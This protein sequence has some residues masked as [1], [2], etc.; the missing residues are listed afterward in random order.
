MVCAQLLSMK[1]RN[2]TSSRLIIKSARRVPTFWIEPDAFLR[3]LP[4]I[5]WILNRNS[6]QKILEIGS[7]DFGLSTY[8]K[9]PLIKVDISFQR[10]QQPFSWK[11]KADALKLPFP[12]HSFDLV[13]SV[14]LLEHILPSN[15][16][17]ILEEMVR[18]SKKE[19]IAIFPCG[20]EARAQDLAIA[21]KFEKDTG[22]KLEIL[23]AHEEIPF[24]EE[25]EIVNWKKLLSGRIKNFDVLK[26]FNL[27]LR[28]KLIRGWLRQNHSAI[29]VAHL[30]IK[31][32][33]LGRLLDFGTCYRRLFKLKIKT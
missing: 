1:N 20:E 14:D 18:I 23:R 32:R 2:I 6:S 3:Y 8:F 15:R 16:I 31:S 28:E 24:P 19:V 9:Y 33:L 30:L 4:I 10:P 27:K 25:S 17:K 7:G 21:S 11:V 26:L 29:R 13:F 12:D 22:R 5:Q